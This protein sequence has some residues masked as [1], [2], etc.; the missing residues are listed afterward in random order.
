MRIARASGMAVAKVMKSTR[1]KVADAN[2]RGPM[3]IMTARLPAVPLAM[4]SLGAL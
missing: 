3:A 1:G 2:P 4:T